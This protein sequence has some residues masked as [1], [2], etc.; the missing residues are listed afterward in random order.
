M[1]V[2]RLTRVDALLKRAIAE[3]L[4]HIM[5]DGGFDLAAVTVT[6]VNSSPNLR[7]AT[8]FVSIRGN[9]KERET[10]LRQLKAHRAQIQSVLNK[11]LVLK[12]TPVLRFVTDD[13]TEKGDKILNILIN[14][15]HQD[16]PPAQDK[17]P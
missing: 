3:A 13:S 9:E 1:S 4:F 12:Y 5:N 2:S 7:H 15:E 10:M 11:D 8:V 14:M 6:K 16:K 17:E